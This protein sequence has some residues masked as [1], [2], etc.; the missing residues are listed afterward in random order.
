M[1][2]TKNERFME[3]VSTLFFYDH[4]FNDR[5]GRS[6]NKISALS[7]NFPRNRLVSLSSKHFSSANSFPIFQFICPETQRYAPL[8]IILKAFIKIDLHCSKILKTRYIL[9]PIMTAD[10]A[11]TIV[12]VGSFEWFT[13]CACPLL[14]WFWSYLLNI[15]PS[16]QILYLHRDWTTLEAT[17]HRWDRGSICCPQ[18][19]WK[20]FRSNKAC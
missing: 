15:P 2:E 20:I 11:Y 13:T 16:N 17:P 5:R 10:G 19:R 12:Y 1:E 4:E 18:G 6:C 14:W 7:F 3:Q 8:V 9:L